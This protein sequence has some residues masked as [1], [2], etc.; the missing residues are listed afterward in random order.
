MIQQDIADNATA[1]IAAAVP[2]WH[3]YSLPQSCEGGAVVSATA[4]D[5]CAFPLI[6]GIPAVLREEKSWV[7]WQWE[8]RDGERKKKPR[9]A[10]RAG[11]GSSTDSTT[12]GTFQQVTAAMRGGAYDGVGFVL[13]A[14]N[15]F[16]GLDLDD[17]VDAVTGE[18]AAWAMAWV[19]RFDSYTEYSVSST[20]LHI[21]MCATLPGNKGIGTG[22]GDGGGLYND[23][24]LFFCTGNHLAGTPTTVEDRQAVVDA[25]LA[26]CVP[27]RTAKAANGSTTSASNLTD[28]EVL[29]LARRAK[30]G[31]KFTQLWAGEWR[32]FDYASQS[33]ADAALLCMLVFY[34]RDEEQLERLFSVSALGQR[35]KWQER[36]D[37]RQR[38]IEAAL[39]MVEEGHSMKQHE[40]TQLLASGDAGLSTKTRANGFSLV[41]RNA[42]AITPRETEW[43]WTDYLAKGELHILGG[44]AAGGKSTLTTHIAATL[45]NG[46]TWPDG[47]P[48]PRVKT[49]FIVP[50]DTPETSVLPRLIANGANREMIE[51]AQVAV[52]A[53]DKESLFDVSRHR[54]ALEAT[55]REKG[56][57]LVVIDPLSGAMPSADRN[58]E[59]A[60]RDRLQPLI[61][62]AQDTGAAV[63]GIMH[64]GKPNGGSRRAE[65][66]LLGSVDY[67]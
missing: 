16:C 37:Y 50:E 18:V 42:S 39:A 52:D 29:Q 47:T 67:G 41:V 40:A 30:N 27:Q 8:P 61:K 1:P 58:N 31:V 49:L 14:G 3:P 28:E 38:T 17:C 51:I 19:A 21:I 22:F 23:K 35:E 60:V 13:H 43:L 48:A 33:N 46:G 6:E 15:P 24:R 20:G 7:G 25:Y 2:K 57:G 44:H 56:I 12:W 32:N 62:L 65:Q 64:T 45:S 55:I 36:E 10:T 9:H 26:E 63:V 53:D 11:Y 5:T 59:G 4:N 54:E 34:T 66:Q